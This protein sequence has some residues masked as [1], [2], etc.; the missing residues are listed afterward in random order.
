[1]HPV[2]IVPT[3]RVCNFLGAFFFLAL[4]YSASLAC[5]R[6][7]LCFSRARV[8]P[9]PA[10]TTSGALS[11]LAPLDEMTFKRLLALQNLMNF[12]LP[13]FGG[14]NP[15]GFRLMQSPESRFANRLKNIVDGDL[16]WR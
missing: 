6:V 16:V 5:T 7:Q 3:V 11:L 15:K 13:H 1:M 9:L 10:G 4:P 12:V 14:L 2:N 8:V